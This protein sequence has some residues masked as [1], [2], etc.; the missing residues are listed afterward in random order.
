MVSASLFVMLAALVEVAPAIVAMLAV[1]A[2]CAAHCAGVAAVPVL[3]VLAAS[4]LCAVDS[5]DVM[6][7]ALVEMLASLLVM[8]TERARSVTV[9]GG[10]PCAG[11]KVP[12]GMPA[13]A[14][15]WRLPLHRLRC[16]LADSA[17]AARRAES[18]ARGP[19]VG[20]PFLAKNLTKFA[21]I[22]FYI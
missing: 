9:Q 22:F 8:V 13:G 21:T 18:D 16:C 5:S 12:A 20:K 7:A 15:S 19:S 6:L 17:C 10:L 14:Q 3:A 2:L 4:A 11:T 1:S